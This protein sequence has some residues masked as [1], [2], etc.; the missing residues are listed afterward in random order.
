MTK[1][2]ALGRGV[3]ML[4]PLESAIEAA[5]GERVDGGVIN[6][7]RALAKL[8]QPHGTGISLKTGSKA[9]SREKRGHDLYETHPAATR[10]LAAVETLPEVI[11]E[12]ACGPGSIVRVLRAAGH[13]VIATD[14]VE[15]GCDGAE[16][17][18]F[19]APDT[20]RDASA[21]VTNPPYKH[22]AEFVRLALARAP[23]VCMLLRTQFLEGVGRTDLIESGHLRVVYQFRERLPMMHRAGWT[24]KKASS[25]M[26][27]AWFVWDRAHS[28]P[29]S[30]KRISWRDHQ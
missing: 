14:I 28:G 12:C 26:S 22:A 27:F 11:W 21:I 25:A 8:I 18:D 16:I 5:G 29:P 2:E 24:G 10:A 4:S 17:A 3:A 7:R 9:H 20:A 30:I 15:Y 19:L 1:R 23:I 6:H 13:R